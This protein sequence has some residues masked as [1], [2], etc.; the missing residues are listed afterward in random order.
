MN[1]MPSLTLAHPCRHVTPA[2]L[3]TFPSLDPEKLHRGDVPYT[4]DFRAL[5][6]TLLHDWLKADES[7]V[8]A[9]PFQH[10]P[11]FKR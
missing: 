1:P 8:L 10:L 4:S 11:L 5:Y 6:A 3:G 9:Q 7:K 2:F